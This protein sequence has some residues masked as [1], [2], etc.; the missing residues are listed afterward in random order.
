M[1]QTRVIK[2]RVFFPPL[3]FLLG[4]DDGARSYPAGDRPV[5]RGSLQLEEE[6]HGLLQPR[7]QGRLPLHLG[8]KDAQD[9]AR[10]S[11]TSRG[12]H[13]SQSLGRHGDLLPVL[14][15]TTQRACLLP[16]EERETHT[17]FVAA[18]DADQNMFCRHSSCIFNTYRFWVKHFRCA[19]GF[20]EE[21]KVRHFLS[22]ST[23][24]CVLWSEVKQSVHIV[25]HATFIL[26][27]ALL[28]YC[29][30]RTLKKLCTS[31]S[32]LTTTLQDPFETERPTNWFDRIKKK[33]ACL[34]TSTCSP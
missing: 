14:G 10:G 15:L 16:L 7:T 19:S 33:E 9:G 5:P 23:H 30:L 3:S 11:H 31:C 12:V 32:K 28:S 25:Q 24:W 21:K 22:W 1:S 8:H 13:G 2:P 20:E 26:I 17:H 34:R 18:S 27:C 29:S 6:S 4:S